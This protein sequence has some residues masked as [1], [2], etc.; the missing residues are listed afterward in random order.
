MKS[1][2]ALIL[3]SALALAAGAEPAAQQTSLVAANT[4]FAFDLMNQITQA[5][6]DANAF[7]SPYSV[8]CALQM[9]A[10]GAAGETRAEMQRTLKSAD[11]S[12]DSL[13]AAFE[14]L[15]QQIAGR[16]DVILNLANGLWYQEGFHLKPA[17]ADINQKF[18]QAGLAGVNF[19]APESAQTI[20]DWAS[21]ETQGKI[22]EVV[23]FPFPPLTR[24]ILA[25]AIYFK[26]SWAVPFKKALTRPREFDLENGQT[27]QTPMMQQDG[28][29][30]Y[31]E[32]PDFQ[33]VKLPYK[34]ALQME[35]YL[36]QP[37]FTPQKLVTRL[38]SDA[39]WRGTVQT[40]FS[41][42]EG[43]VTLPKFKIEY[44]IELNAVLE[45]LGMKRA[46]NAGAD[47]SGIA[48]EPVFISEVKQKSYVDVNEEGTEAAAVTVVGVRAS[49]IMRPP[50]NRFTM[51]LDRPFLFIISDVNTRSI[52][53]IGIVNDPASGQ[54]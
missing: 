12:A 27:R 48:N 8:S 21:R 9:T 43:S 47:F 19:G 22:K 20:N 34:G 13:Y 44:Q 23:Q 39:S 42:R 10:A 37:G 46:F 25:N 38:A 11:L 54:N 33:A 1:I 18:F 17:F 3:T 51:V 53:F 50:P 41:R 6:P 32:T 4:A 30:I 35:L 28:S 29:F 14:E 16:K 7:I 52:L 31:Q 15:D 26:G 5:H 40:G 36:P 49:A 45:A 2:P 24:L